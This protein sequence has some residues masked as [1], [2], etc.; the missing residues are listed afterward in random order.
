M[1]SMITHGLLSLSRK[2]KLPVYGCYTPQ[3][4]NSLLFLLFSQPDNECHRLWNKKG[5][6]VSYVPESPGV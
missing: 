2:I 6:D 5:R 3:G 4:H 1:K